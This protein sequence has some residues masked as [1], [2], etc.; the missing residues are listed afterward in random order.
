MSNKRTIA[1]VGSTGN[2][3]R[4]LV[5]NSYTSHRLIESV[6]GGSVATIFS[7]LPGWHVQGL[8]RDPSKP[9]ALVWKEKGV[10]LISAD[11]N[12]IESLTKAFSNADVVFGTTDFW[13]HMR[14]PDVHAEANARGITPNEVSYEREAQQAKNIVDAAAANIGTL[15]RL[16][17]STLNDSKYWSKGKVTFNLHF[18]SK[19]LAVEYLKE[20]YPALWE[21]TSLLQVGFYAMNWKTTGMTLPTKTDKEGEYVL[22]MPISGDSKVP[23]VDT[24]ADTGASVPS[25]SFLNDISKLD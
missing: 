25:Q 22:R 16:V 4:T 6:Q 24:V 23:L 3:V 14:D 2:Q 17:L 15:D 21:K 20:K 8:T 11:L 13:G 1:I 7:N 19:W 9:S 5:S 18:D 10:E 12:S